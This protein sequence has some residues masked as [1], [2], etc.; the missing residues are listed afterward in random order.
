MQLRVLSRKLVELGL[1]PAIDPLQSS[2][3]GFMPVWWVKNIIVSASC[4]QAILQRYKELQ[5]VIAILGI[6]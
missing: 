5:D 3:K 1:Y 6:G 2:S 4:N